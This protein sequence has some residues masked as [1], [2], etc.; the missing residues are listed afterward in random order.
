MFQVLFLKDKNHSKHLKFNPGIFEDIP[1]LASTINLSNSISVIDHDL[2]VKHKTSNSITTLW[3]PEVN[4]IY[5]D[6]WKQ[7]FNLFGSEDGKYF[8]EMRRGLRGIVGVCIQI[9]EE[10]TSNHKIRDTYFQELG[11]VIKVKFPFWEFAHL[12]PIE[13]QYDRKYVEFAIRYLM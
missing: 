1:F 8:A 4:P 7:V 3:R 11:D 10:S 9:I 2:Y 5:L 13:S 6:A 12:E